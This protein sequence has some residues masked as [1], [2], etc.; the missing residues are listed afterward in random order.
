MKIEDYNM[1]RWILQVRSKR[2]GVVGDLVGEL[3]Y[4][5]RIIVSKLLPA[6]RSTRPP[7]FSGVLICSINNDSRC[8]FRTS[9]DECIKIPV[10][11]RFLPS[12]ANLSLAHT[13]T[14]F[15]FASSVEP[16][17]RNRRM[18]KISYSVSPSNNIHPAFYSV[19]FIGFHGS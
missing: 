6:Y 13:H 1:R 17:G 3:F 19:P 15:L 2:R 16:I 7:F 10:S 11:G 9:I 12:L 18:R 5:S 4:H 14:P 8:T